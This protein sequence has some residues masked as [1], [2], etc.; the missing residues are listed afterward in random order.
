MRKKNQRDKL[1]N[2]CKNWKKKL[3]ER[4]KRS[5]REILSRNNLIRILRIRENR[6]RMIR[7]KRRRER[8]LRREPEDLP[9]MRESNLITTSMP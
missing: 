2:Q 9:E 3:K 1:K 7:R 4:K 6:N 8:Y 5:S